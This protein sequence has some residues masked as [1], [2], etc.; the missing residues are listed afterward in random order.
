MLCLFLGTH[1][2]VAAEHSSYGLLNLRGG[3]LASLAKYDYNYYTGQVSWDPYLFSVGSLPLFLEAGG[4][5]LKSAADYNFF[6]LEAA[7]LISTPRSG[8]LSFELGAGLQKWFSTPMPLSPQLI[9]NFRLGAT[10]P[11]FGLINGVILGYSYV[12]QSLPLHQI[13]AQ[14]EVSL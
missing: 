3:E 1:S 10:S 2:A 13:K 6:S 5:L 8:S 14:I 4:A 12:K 9:G 7:L 11:W